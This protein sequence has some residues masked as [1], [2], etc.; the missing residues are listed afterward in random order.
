MTYLIKYT[1][2][3]EFSIKTIQDSYIKKLS[4]VDLLQSNFSLN[5]YHKN[6]QNVDQKVK[7]RKNRVCLEQKKSRQSRKCDTNAVGD[8][9]DI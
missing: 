7:P 4:W 1:L 3:R 6:L 2:T 8:V 9:G 5:F